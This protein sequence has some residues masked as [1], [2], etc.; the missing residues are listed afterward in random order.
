MR[1]WFEGD[2]GN[3]Y[4]EGFVGAGARGTVENGVRKCNGFGG[5]RSYWTVLLEVLLVLGTARG[6]MG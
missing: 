3:G 2:W 1:L 4:L 5:G 6:M